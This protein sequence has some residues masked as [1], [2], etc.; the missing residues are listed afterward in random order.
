LIAVDTS[1]LMAI[2]LGEPGSG[3]LM[4]R[5]AAE[6]DV[7][8]SAATLAETLIVADRRSVG[9]AM[10][11]LIDGLAFDIMPVTAPVARRVAASYARW[12][13]G[14]HPAGLNFCDC[15]AYDAARV[16]N[17]PLLFVG[18]DFARTDVNDIG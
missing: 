11:G 12:G 2:V 13:K 17:C 9:E 3:A 1:A 18:E 7:V 15:F 10:A 14:L 6:D 4:D 8:M 5:L 16:N